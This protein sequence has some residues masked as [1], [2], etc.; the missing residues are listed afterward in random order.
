MLKYY[1]KSVCLKAYYECFKKE[2][3][4]QNVSWKNALKKNKLPNEI[5]IDGVYVKVIDSF[6]LLG[7]DNKLNFSE[8]CLNIKI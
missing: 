4:F 3:M 8:Q 6:K 5:F 7:V 2:F 1:F